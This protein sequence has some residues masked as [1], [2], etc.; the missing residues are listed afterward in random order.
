MNIRIKQNKKYEHKVQ[1]K[2]ESKSEI[3]LSLLFISSYLPSCVKSQFL[4]KNVVYIHDTLNTFN[5]MLSEAKQ[6]W[7]W[8][9]LGWVDRFL[10]RYQFNPKYKKTT[11]HNQ[12][13]CCCADSE[14]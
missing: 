6:H 12:G 1:N 9:A 5:L 14:N 8:V 11:Q 2:F 13:T 3:Q 7:A 10:Q 4:I